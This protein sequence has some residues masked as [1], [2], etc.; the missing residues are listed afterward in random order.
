MDYFQ[1][2]GH[3]TGKT[4]DIVY[5]FELIISPLLLKCYW[6]GASHEPLDSESYLGKTV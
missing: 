2:Y 4:Q 3:D 5:Y 6:E 1:R